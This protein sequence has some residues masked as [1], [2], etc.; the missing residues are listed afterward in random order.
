MYRI[1]KLKN[2]H[3][4]PRKTFFKCFLGGYFYVGDID[5]FYTM[6]DF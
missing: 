1:P 4:N 5:D 2:V 6:A 3:M